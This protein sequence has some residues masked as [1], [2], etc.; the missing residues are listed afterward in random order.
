VFICVCQWERPP[1]ERY[2]A[3]IEESVAQVGSPI[4]GERH[5]AAAGEIHPAQQEGAPKL[6]DKIA[7]RDAD[8]LQ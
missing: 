1:D 6:I 7:A 8:H 2:L 5:L 4:G 3:V